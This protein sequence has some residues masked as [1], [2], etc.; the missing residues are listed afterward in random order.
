MDVYLDKRGHRVV[1]ECCV[2]FRGEWVV[3][4]HSL[5]LSPL[6]QCAPQYAPQ[7][8]G[9]RC[10]GHLQNSVRHDRYLKCEGLTAYLLLFKTMVT[11]D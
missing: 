1:G 7:Y 10:V 4:P 11:D 8:V 2:W 5:L 6:L 3:F 9:M